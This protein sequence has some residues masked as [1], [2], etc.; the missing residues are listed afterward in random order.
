MTKPAIDNNFCPICNMWSGDTVWCRCDIPDA[1][2]SAKLLR[3]IYVLVGHESHERIREMI[4]K[5]LR[6]GEL[7]DISKVKE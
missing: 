5:L 3:R 4:I 7:E 6:S 1:E 2:L